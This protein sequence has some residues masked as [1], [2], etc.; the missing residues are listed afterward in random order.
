MI[1]TIK[2]KPIFQK[3]DYL[4]FTYFDMSIKDRRKFDV[5]DIYDNKVECG[6]CGWIIRSK[7]R[8]D[9]VYCKCGKTSVD[10]GSWY[11]KVGGDNFK[12]HIVYYKF[13]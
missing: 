2:Q 3:T 6:Y 12:S 13:I 9:M 5:G 7:N 8:H 11:Q 10:G 1:K 4:D